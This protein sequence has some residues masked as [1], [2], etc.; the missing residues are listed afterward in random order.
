MHF[1]DFFDMSITLTPPP[2]KR[3]STGAK[4]KWEVFCDLGSTFSDFWGPAD[5]LEI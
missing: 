2:A 4:K 1:S 3:E 5:R